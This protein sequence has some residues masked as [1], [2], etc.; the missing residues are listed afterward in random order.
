MDARNSRDSID[1]IMC[2]VH[3]GGWHPEFGK[4][5]LWSGPATVNVLTVFY[6]WLKLK[7]FKKTPFSTH[8]SLTSNENGQKSFI[9]NLFLVQIFIYFNINY[10]G[11]YKSVITV[12]LK[13]LLQYLKLNWYLYF[14]TPLLCLF[15]ILNSLHLAFKNSFT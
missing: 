10:N 7:I 6:I 2:I 13:L 8:N 5:R 15:S 11:K 14:K 1:C 4:P 12:L 3:N 9:C